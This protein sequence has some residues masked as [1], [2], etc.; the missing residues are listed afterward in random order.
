MENPLLDKWIRYKRSANST[1]KWQEIVWMI[2][3]KGK[4]QRKL[5][6]K[7]NNE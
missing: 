1:P 7:I 4:Q 3:E 2:A 5:I 6:L